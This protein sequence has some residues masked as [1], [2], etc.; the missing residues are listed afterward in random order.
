VSGLVFSGGHVHAA[1]LKKLFAARENYRRL[2]EKCDWGLPKPGQ[3]F[4][5]IIKLSPDQ[6][7]AR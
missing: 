4:G 2:L 6:K 7:Q 5:K 3:L 1:V